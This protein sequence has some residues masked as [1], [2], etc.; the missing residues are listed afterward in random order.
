MALLSWSTE[1]SVEVE[2]IDEQHQQLFA[3]LN[4][5]HDAMKAGKGTE[6]APLVLKKLAEYV[7]EHFAWEEALMAKA[8][9]PDLARHKAEHD[10]LTNE[11]AKMLQEL[12]SGKTVL[13]MK[14]QGFLRSWLQEHILGCDKKYVSYL[15]R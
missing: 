14:L 4:E 6:Q 1:Y 3:M 7:C 11:V 9:Y 15:S 5:L 12:E 13:S 8:G 2:S 10:K